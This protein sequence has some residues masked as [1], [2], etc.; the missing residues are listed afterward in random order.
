MATL[1]PL[2]PSTA[3]LQ[4]SKTAPCECGRSGTAALCLPRPASGVPG[5]EKRSQARRPAPGWS[6][7]WGHA[8]LGA[9]SQPRTGGPPLPRPALRGTGP[10]RCGWG[11][12]SSAPPDPAAQPGSERPPEKVGRE[13]SESA[14]PRRPRAAPRRAAISAAPG[15][16]VRPPPRGSRSPAPSRSPDGSVGAGAHEL[17][18][19]VAVPH[20]PEGFG[21]LLP[22]EAVL[23][24]GHSA[25]PLPPPPTKSP[26][27][28]AERR[29]GLSEPR[30]RAW[31]RSFRAS[32]S[33][34]LSPAPA[35]LPRQRR[36]PLGA[37]PGPAPCPLLSAGGDARRPGG[38]SAWKGGDPAGAGHGRNGAWQCCSGDFPHAARAAYAALAVPA[39]QRLQHF[40]FPPLSPQQRGQSRAAARVDGEGSSLTALELGE[41]RCG[42]DRSASSSAV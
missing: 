41:L 6:P 9:R 17:Q 30:G 38:L 33:P 5:T 10:P 37:P 21:D 19:P 12:L 18:V 40:C 36:A 4:E 42:R 22:V 28:S 15:P 1:V 13:E 39:A 31:P 8:R 14:A 7:G 25:R 32:L 3:E 2:L 29:A 23:G 24:G 35:P 27:G 26:G 34:S 20:F 11:R 16:G